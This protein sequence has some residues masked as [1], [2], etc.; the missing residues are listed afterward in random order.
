MCSAEPHWSGGPGEN[1][2]KRNTF[3]F[4]DRTRIPG[5][6]QTI[7][8][9]MG[10]FFFHGNNF[11]RENPWGAPGTAPHDDRGKGYSPCGYLQKPDGGKY[12]DYDS[13]DLP[14]ARQGPVTKWQA[15][16]VVE[17]A[18]SIGANHGGGYSYRLCKAPQGH[19]GSMSSLT[20]ACFQ[21][22][23]LKFV[24]DLS[25]A[26]YNDDSNNRKE[27]KAKRTTSGTHPR[28]SQWTRNP[29]PAWKCASGGRQGYKFDGITPNPDKCNEFN[30]P[31]ASPDLAGYGLHMKKHQ[32]VFNFHIVDKLQVP[33]NLAPGDYVL[34]WRWDC[35]QTPQVWGQCSN[36][37]IVSDKTD[38]SNQDGSHHKPDPADQHLMMNWKELPN[39]ACRAHGGDSTTDGEGSAYRLYEAAHN[40]EVCK[41]SCAQNVKCTGVEFAS[42]FKHCEIWTRPIHHDVAAGGFT[43]FRLE[44]RHPQTLYASL[45]NHL[46]YIQ[47]EGSAAIAPFSKVTMAMAAGAATTA[48]ALAAVAAWRKRDAIWTRVPVVWTRVPVVDEKEQQSI[49]PE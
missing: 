39:R 14:F 7:P 8:S 3:W 38:N 40:L 19:G 41:W 6:R 48:I 26:Q 10:T 45:P 27:I 4:S 49:C 20:E 5:R 23:H 21:A 11:L 2:R 13:R 1:W 22:G 42:H 24:G 34:S 44:N 28:G 17:A 32:D 16:S 25:W 35:E 47:G 15:G 30:F 43:C 18:F 33:S 9:S 46:P 37:E 12:G 31:P 36:I 29:I